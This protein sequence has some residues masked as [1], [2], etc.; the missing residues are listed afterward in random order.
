MLLTPRVL[1]CGLVACSL[2]CLVAIP[3]AAAEDSA[4][5]YGGGERLNTHTANGDRFDPT[6]LTCAS[7][8][9][10]FGTILRVTNLA[11]GRTVL[12]RVNDRGPAKRLRRAI[13]LSRA[14]FA[15]LADLKKGLIRVEIVPVP[16]RSGAGPVRDA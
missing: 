7:W 14:A 15:R 12:V 11:N 2:W 13:D 16:H 8:D 1:V 4:S 6:A 10:P 9:Y 5:W 3:T